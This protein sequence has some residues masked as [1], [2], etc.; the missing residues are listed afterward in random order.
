MSLSIFAMIFTVLCAPTMNE[1]AQNLESKVVQT[2]EDPYL[3][4]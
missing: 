2:E 4:S 1:V 3:N